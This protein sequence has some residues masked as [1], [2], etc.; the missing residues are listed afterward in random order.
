[1][2]APD[3]ALNLVLSSYTQ[4]L[5]AKME[6]SFGV[7][8]APLHNAFAVEDIDRVYEMI[9]KTFGIDWGGGFDGWYNRAVKLEARAKR[10]LNGLK[11]ALLPGVDM[12]A[13]LAVYLAG[14]GMEPLIVNIEDFHNE[15]LVYAKQLKAMGFDPPVCRMMNIDLDITVV[16][17]LNP[18]ISFG[19]MPDPIE[20]FRCAEDMGD[21]FGITGYERTAGIL[22]RLFT[23][24]ETGQSGERM[25][26]YGPAPV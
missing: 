17:R 5:A 1:M 26:L 2:N 16:K 22:S 4:P 15:D 11:Y 12:P 21:F 13:A 3:A 7:P 19:Y 20:G 10:E 9:A 25:E 6:A 24:L 18:D 23:V 8:C 14:F